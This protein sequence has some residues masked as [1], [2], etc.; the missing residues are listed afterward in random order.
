MCIDTGLA[1]C[2]D[3]CLDMCLD[4][5]LDMRV[6]ICLDMCSDMYLVIHLDINL[7]MCVGMCLDMHA[8][9]GMRCRQETRNACMQGM[10]C[11][12]WHTRYDMLCLMWAI[13]RYGFCRFSGANG[14]KSS[15][16]TGFGLCS[17]MCMDMCSVTAQ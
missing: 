3:T 17:D 2:L 12:V 8:I 14:T 13:H 15:M 5:Y 10:A 9:H 6:D 7:D 11:A 1:V 4:T 16:W